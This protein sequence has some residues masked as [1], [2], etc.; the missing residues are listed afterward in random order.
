MT[1]RVVIYARSQRRVHLEECPVC[2]HEFEHNEDRHLH[3]ATHDPEDFGLSPKGETADG[4]AE[5]LFGG[6]AC[7]D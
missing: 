1:L 4:H 5:P 7:G 2:P 3:I 6:E